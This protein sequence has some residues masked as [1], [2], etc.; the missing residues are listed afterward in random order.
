MVMREEYNALIKRLD[1]PEN[2]K[3]RKKL[4]IDPNGYDLT[5]HFKRINDYVNNMHESNPITSELMEL[6]Y[7]V[8]L[9]KAK[10]IMDSQGW[11]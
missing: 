10:E 3:L 1:A 7:M 11:K 2:A 4:P 5:F 6:D 8:S 9:R